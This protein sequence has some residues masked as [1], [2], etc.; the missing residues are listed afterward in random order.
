MG[1]L[2]VCSGE[3]SRKSHRNNVEATVNYLLG[4]AV[5]SLMGGIYPVQILGTLRSTPAHAKHA[6]YLIHYRSVYHAAK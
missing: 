5:Y 6:P 1:T 2:M 4:S 3:M